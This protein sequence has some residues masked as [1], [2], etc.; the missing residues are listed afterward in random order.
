MEQL[1]GLPEM[2]SVLTKNKVIFDGE[3]PADV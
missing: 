3:S 2:T 1:T